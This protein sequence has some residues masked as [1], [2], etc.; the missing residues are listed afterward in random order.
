MKGRVSK[1][2]AKAAKKVNAKAGKSVTLKTNV[3]TT[4]GKPVNKALKWTSSNPE[5][6]MV[7]GNGRLAANA[8]VQIVK[9]AV[10]GKKVT[11]TA[12]STD[13]TNKK[14]KFTITVK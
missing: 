7:K 9:G 13:G 8:K 2:T 1:V 11:I 4:G 12:V 5:I 6:A 10:K 14:L 3:K